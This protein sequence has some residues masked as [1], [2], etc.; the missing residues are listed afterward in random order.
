MFFRNSKKP[1]GQIY[2]LNQNS[3]Y[4]LDI[5]APYM[6]LSI[7]HALHPHFISIA[8][9]DGNGGSNILLSLKSIDSSYTLPNMK[10]FDGSTSDVISDSRR[11][12]RQSFR[13]MVSFTEIK[14]PT[15]SSEAEKEKYLQNTKAA[16]CICRNVKLDDNKED[17]ELLEL[18]LNAKQPIEKLFNAPGALSECIAAPTA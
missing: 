8:K 14:F 6:A 1:N 10:K 5:T 18:M 16:F 12:I 15:I 11:Y 7:N 17:A 3:I 13:D 2:F 4:T 9:A